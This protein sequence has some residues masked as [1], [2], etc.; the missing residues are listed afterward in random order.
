MFCVQVTVRFNKQLAVNR[1][2]RKQIEVLRYQRNLFEKFY[3]RLAQQMV[4]SKKELKEI[5]ENCKRVYELRYGNVCCTVW[6]ISVLRV[7]GIIL[8]VYGCVAD[9]FAQ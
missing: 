4:K 8:V 6:V 5:L 7:C 3:N 1:D 9:I 2:L